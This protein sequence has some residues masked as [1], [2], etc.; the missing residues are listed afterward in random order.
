MANKYIARPNMGDYSKT[1]G[2]VIDYNKE[3]GI[4]VIRFGRVKK[5]FSMDLVKIKKASVKEGVTV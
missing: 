5:T 1:W 2:E 4:V 3:Y